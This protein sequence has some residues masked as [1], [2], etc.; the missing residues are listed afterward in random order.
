MLSVGSSFAEDALLKL[1]IE[2]NDGSDGRI[3]P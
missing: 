1:G 2:D 3:D